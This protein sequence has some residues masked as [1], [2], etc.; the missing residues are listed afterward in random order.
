MHGHG[1]ARFGIS[2]VF[3]KKLKQIV[4]GGNKR[5]GITG[6]IFNDG[7]RGLFHYKGAT[8]F[9]VT[10]ARGASW[11]VELERKIGEAMAN[12]IIAA[13]GN[14]SGAVCMNL[15]RHPAW[16]RAQETY[17]EDP[18][19]VGEMAVAL[20][21]GIQHHGVQACVKHFAANSM[22]NNRFGGSINMSERTLHEVYLPHFKKTVDSGAASVMSAYN[23]LNGEYCGHNKYLLTEVLRKQWGF[24]GYITSDWSYGLFD[25]QKGIEAGMNV[26]MPTGKVYK[27]K[28]IRQLLHTGKITMQQVDDLVKPILYTKFYF[29]SLPRQ[30]FNTSVIGCAE[31]IALAQ[32]AAEK[33]AVL[34]KNENQVLPLSKN[35]KRIAIIGTL[36][37]VQ[38]TGDRGSS[39]VTPSYIVSAYDGLKK[40]VAPFGAEVLTCNVHDT[41]AIKTICSNADAVIVVAGTT[42]Q[43][44]G[45]YIGNFTIRDRNNPDKQN[46]VVKAGILGLGG[47][48]KYLH[49]HLP[50]IQAIQI[51]A[52]VNKNVVVNLVAGSAITVEEWYGK[53]P[54]ILQTFYNGMEGGT[55]LARLLFGEVSPSGKLPFTVPKNE[56]DLPPFDSY[57][58]TVHYGYYHGYTLFEKENK[59]PRFPFG[60]GLSY[61]TFST[62]QLLVKEHENYIEIKLNVKNTGVIKAAEVVQAYVSFPQTEVEMPN[63]LLRG[64]KKIELLPGEEKQVTLH[65]PLSSLQYYNE[66]LHQWQPTKG[67]HTVFVGNSSADPNML[68]ATFTR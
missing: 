38:Q 41:V 55:A 35:I 27:Y 43:D 44:E 56:N 31:H 46:F 6:T 36:A 17:G 68:S 67:T 62:S 26:E 57:A 60:F 33:S 7:P 39:S 30:T 51:A 23:K 58:D 59:Q 10:M 16:G 63:K 54:A 9:P 45:E 18:W 8:A 32:E 66:Q 12:E 34:L 52:A 19:H 2:M 65:I 28:T 29:N 42:Y 61:T 13:D 15:L 50:D 49:L 22:E 5:W 37:T 64:F 14:Y 3:G 4:A 53:T 48:R 47:D 11:D 40:Y 24:K 20:V 1:I 25:A 21:K